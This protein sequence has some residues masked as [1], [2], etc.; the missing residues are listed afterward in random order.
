MPAPIVGRA[1]TDASILD[2]DRIRTVWHALQHPALRLPVGLVLTLAYI[3]L[4][5][6]PF[7]WNPP[8]LLENGAQIDADGGTMHFP[9]PGLIR[10]IEPPDWLASAR[11]TGRLHLTLRVRPHADSTSGTT[12]FLTIARDSY[13]RNLALSQRGDDL[14]LSLRTPRPAG[15]RRSDG[16]SALI[17]LRDVFRAGVWATFDL[18]IVPGEL[19][20][21]VDGKPLAEMPLDRNPLATWD[22]AHRLAFGN[23]VK[24]S[25][26]WLGDLED[27][28]V[29]AG[30]GPVSHVEPAGLERPDAFLVTS[31]EPKLRLFRYLEKRDVAINL[32]LYAPLGIFL[33]LS[34]RADRP[35]ALIRALCM[36]ALL[37]GSLEV[38]QLFVS[39]RNPSINDLILN[40]AG[41]AIGFLAARWLVSRLGQ[42]L[43]REK[44]TPSS[45]G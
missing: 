19:V 25:R 37:S 41:G 24:G 29:R 10:T 44:I 26:P 3:A 15:T 43:L 2:G 30:D 31:R 21:A 18:T 9:T 45:I 13:E 28:R 11:E 27:V 17:R 7:S 34:R 40:V 38:A 42:A 14:I 23:Q 35:G 16:V 22:T 5:T 39:V 1:V 4:L 32:V 20:M 8:S 36:I 6:W 12:P 33:G